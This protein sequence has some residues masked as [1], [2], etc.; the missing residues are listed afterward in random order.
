MNRHNLDTKIKMDTKVKIR[1]FPFIDNISKMQ[2]LKIDNESIHFI[3]IRED[4]HMITKFIIN[5][6]IFNEN[7][8]CCDLYITDATAGVGG[9]TI[10]FAK[11]FKYVNAIEIN[12]QRFNY[13]QN[14][15]NVYDLDNVNVFNNNCLHILDEIYHDI[16]FIDPPWGGKNY[17]NENMLRLKLDENDI[18]TV[19][20]NILKGTRCVVLKLPLN[21]DIRYLKNILKSFNIKIKKLNKMLIILIHKTEHMISL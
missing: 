9:N 8:Q 4:A 7:E 11:Y 1:L 21:Y 20:L 6:F 19:C 13:L 15:V 5:N 2:N 14:N 3:S 12:K 18:E 16:V 10:S 17:K